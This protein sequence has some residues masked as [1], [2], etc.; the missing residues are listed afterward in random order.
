[1]KR[2]QH[3]AAILAAIVCFGGIWTVSVPA[4]EKEHEDWNQNYITSSYELFVTEAEH[5]YYFLVDDYIYYM[6]FDM[7]APVFLCSKPNCMHDNEECNA[8]LSQERLNQVIYYEGALYA[9]EYMGGLRE[10]LV[11][12]SADGETRETLFEVYDRDG[13]DMLIHR[14]KLYYT[15]K[16]EDSCNIMAYNL[17]TGEQQMVCE[18]KENEDFCQLFAWDHYLYYC[19]RGINEEE[20]YYDYTERFSL[21]DGT[22]TEIFAAAPEMKKEDMDSVSLPRRAENGSIYFFGTEKDQLYLLLADPEGKEA[23]IKA[24]VIFGIVCF[25]GDYLYTATM[26]SLQSDKYLYIYTLDGECMEKMK[27]EP[28]EDEYVLHAIMAAGSGTTAFVSTT[29]V[30]DTKDRSFFRIWKLDK[31]LIGTDDFHLKLLI[32]TEYRIT[33]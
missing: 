20:E 18:G 5:G 32:D 10:E 33:E 9:F 12:I 2:I 3:K 17:D 7:E 30:P 28:D 22:V 6:D 25:D 21:E 29:I 15:Q 13:N 4:Q 14:G 11:K 27:I 31:T 16:T 26:D 24:K 19:V 1:M 23:T 8:Y